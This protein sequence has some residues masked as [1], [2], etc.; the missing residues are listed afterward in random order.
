MSETKP[1]IL[2]L[3]IE[4]A[5]AVGYFWNLFDQ[6]IGLNQLIKPSEILCWAAKWFGSKNEYFFASWGQGGK[7]EML[8]ALHSLMSVADA[9]V[10]YNGDK[11]DNPW[12]LG[13]FAK[14]GL[15]PLPPLVSIDLYKTA[16]RFKM[17]SNKLAYVAPF[18]GLGSKIGTDFSLWRGVMDGDEKSRAK[19]ERYNIRDVRLLERV[20]K[21]LRPYVKNHPYLGDRGSCGACGS[22]ELQS[23]GQRRT[24]T[25]SVQRLQCQGCGSWSDG[26]RKKI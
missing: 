21:K 24:R 9:I 22:K 5:P 1:K 26:A 23:R 10:T 6:N 25:F 4:T 7:D 12:V 18:F 11:F 15:S 8:R 16:K 17:Q 2:L 14:A 3:D 13:E 19:M 20:Y